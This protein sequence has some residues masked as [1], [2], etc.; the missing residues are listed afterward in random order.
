M[1]IGCENSHMYDS[2]LVSQTVSCFSPL[3]DFS[4]S[5]IP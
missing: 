2:P 3:S 5:L 4:I 1:L